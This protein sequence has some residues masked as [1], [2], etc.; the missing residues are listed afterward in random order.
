MSTGDYL[1]IESFF[2]SIFPNNEDVVISYEIKA[3]P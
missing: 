3:V 1:T 2:I